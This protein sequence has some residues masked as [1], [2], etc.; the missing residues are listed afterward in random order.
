[1]SIENQVWFITGVSSGIGNAIATQALQAGT[2]VVGTVRHENQVS[3]FE[4]LS[5]ENAI[6]VKM[7][8]AHPEQIKSGIQAAIDKFGKIDVLVNNAGYGIVGALEETSDEEARRLFNT[9]FFG[10]FEVTKA[11]LPIMRQQRSGRIITLSA[12]AGFTGFPGFALYGAS[13]FAIEGLHESLAK[14]VQPLNIKVTLITAGVFRTRFA[15]SSLQFT[16]K[17]IDDYAETAG[18]FRGHIS[19]LDGNQPNDP[20]KA[21]HAILEIAEAEN[22]PT[23]L[24]LGEDAVKWA[25]EK[26]QHIQEELTSWETLSCST[27]IEEMKL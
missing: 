12:I 4:K 24:I 10:T 2:S 1:M 7:D 22:P 27:K 23:R 16:E 11:V 3:E 6:A 14:E 18:R 17:V 15:G 5:P 9:N 13:K 21:A 19:Q 8:I 25:N 26:I 20:I